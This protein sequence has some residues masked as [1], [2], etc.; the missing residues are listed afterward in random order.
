MN[1]LRLHKDGEPVYVNAD[2]LAIIWPEKGLKAR[3]QFQAPAGSM[4][5]DESVETVLSLL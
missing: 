5:V 3:L 2:A 4:V 1:F